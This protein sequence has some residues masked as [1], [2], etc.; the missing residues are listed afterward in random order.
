VSA[1]HQSFDELAELAE[2]LLARK[3]ARAAQDHLA[4]CDECTAR[5]ASLQHATSALRDLGPV[6]MPADVA[7]RLDRALAGAGDE[8]V[9][10]TVVP[11]LTAIRQRR[12]AP[13]PWTMAAAAAVVLIAAVSTIV[14]THG[15]HHHPTESALTPA[16]ETPLVATSAQHP[17]I[18]EESGRTYTPATLAAL[19]P[20]LVNDG[21][22]ATSVPVGGT[23]AGAS[24]SG[25]GAAAPAVPAPQVPT[26]TGAPVHGPVHKEAGTAPSFATGGTARTGPED[27]QALVATEIPAP[28]Q[29]Y[30]NS[31]QELLKC[32]AFITDTPG[33]TPEAVD[34]ARWSNPKTHAVRTPALILVF[35]DPQDSSE[36]DVYVVAP[37]CDD[38]SLLDFQLL[39]AS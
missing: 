28:L 34:Y 36:I 38:S 29:R 22:G 3:A 13:P 31:Q 1:G 2:G 23:G 18:T 17:P 6:S 21:F 10:D 30:A 14:T 4:S 5:A 11:D 9:G 16:S 33:A 20:G 27:S 12:Q 35:A 24:S 37:P 15:G 7:A 32:A 39:S 19:A 8:P 26:S 25:S